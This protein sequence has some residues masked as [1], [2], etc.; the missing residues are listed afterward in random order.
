MRSRRAAKFAEYIST[1]A[2]VQY[3][4]VHDTTVV[5][6]KDPGT[7]VG[8]FVRDACDANTTLLVVPSRRFGTCS[9][10]SAV[11]APLNS[12]KLPLVSLHPLDDGIV[13]YLSGAT[14]AQEWVTWCWRLSLETFRSYSPLWGWLQML[15]SSAE[16]AERMQA[17]EQQCAARYPPIL[18]HYVKAKQRIEKEICSAYALLEPHVITP[19]LKVFQW[20]T[21]VLLSRGVLCPVAWEATRRSST[22]AAP[23]SPEL[24][25]MPYVDLVNGGDSIGRSANSTIEVAATVADLPD[26]YTA[27]LRDEFLRKN[28]TNGAALADDYLR[29]AF[30]YHYYA[31]LTLT[32]PLLPAEEVILDYELPIVSTGTLSEGEDKILSRLLKYYYV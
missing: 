18:P 6:R 31:C 19:P 1:Y 25:V 30:D 22:E 9:V 16:F 27:W 14:S 3:V 20:A 11:G 8:V 5:E 4:G 26:W 29:W 21:W 24:G 13:S 23:R 12:D 7:G 10:L 17:A 2:I 15:P 32:K 28:R